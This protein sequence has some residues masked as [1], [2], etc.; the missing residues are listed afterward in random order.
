M[1]E[2]QKSI[3]KGNLRKVLYLVLFCFSV[4]SLVPN[5]GEAVVVSDSQNVAGVQRAKDLAQ[6]RAVLERK[7]IESRLESF[8]LSSAEIEKRLSL[9]TDEEL[10]KLATE[11]DRLNP[12]G[13]GALVILLIIALV[14]VILY[15]T[16]VIDFNVKVEKKE[17]KPKKK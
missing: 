5:T 13:Q 10:H 8:G 11:L 1:R 9:L 3:Q 2:L 12:G 14:V 16:G 15:Y 7:E 6:I 17:K 4:L